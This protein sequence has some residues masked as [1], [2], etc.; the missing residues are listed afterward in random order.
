MLTVPH[1]LQY[2]EDC[3]KHFESSITQL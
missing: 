2:F 3:S 1:L